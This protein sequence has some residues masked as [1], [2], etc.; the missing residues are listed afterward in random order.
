MPE[1]SYFGRA[2]ASRAST[3]LLYIQYHYI[4]YDSITS[5]LSFEDISLAY[6]MSHMLV[7]RLSVSVA[8]HRYQRLL[9]G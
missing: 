4:L 2:L 1:D 5:A 8:V 9:L 3:T 6:A 7:A